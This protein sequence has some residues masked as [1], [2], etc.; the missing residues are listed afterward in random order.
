MTGMTEERLQKERDE[1]LG[2]TAEDIRALAGPVAAAME[3]GYICVVGNEE[4][5]MAESSLF[6]SVRQL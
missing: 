6:E 2:A 1:V 4:R 3:Q 5:L